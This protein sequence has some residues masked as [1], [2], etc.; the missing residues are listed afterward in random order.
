M[1]L[2]DTPTPAPAASTSPA[3]LRFARSFLWIMFGVALALLVALAIA[4]AWFGAGIMT[5]VGAV[6]GTV[7]LTYGIR[8]FLRNPWTRLGVSY[9]MLACVVIYL[10]VDEATIRRPLTLEA[11]APTFPGAEKSYEIF[12]RYGKHH[13]L[14]RDFRLQTSPKLYQGQGVWKPKDPQWSAWIT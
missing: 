8:R 14:G 5:G 13:P 9:A 10:A 6:L 12:M 2:N 4:S 11:I 7:A 3:A 1:H